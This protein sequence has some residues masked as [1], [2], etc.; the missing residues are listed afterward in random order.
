LA[1]PSLDLIGGKKG[2]RVWKMKRHLIVSFVLVLLFLVLAFPISPVPRGNAYA[3]RP[4]QLLLDVTVNAYLLPQC[5]DLSVRIAMDG[6]F[7]DYTTPH[8]FFLLNGTH[9]FTVPN[10]D[11]G[12]HPFMAWSTGEKTP[13]IIASFGGTYTAYYGVSPPSTYNVTVDTSFNGAGN[14]NVAITEDGVPT[15]F[16]TPYTFS[17]LV[18][19][20]NFTV[21]STD[22][23]GHPFANWV[24][25]SGSLKR[26]TTITVS[27]GGTYTACYDIGLCRFVTPSDQAVVAVASNKSW[28]EMLDYVSSHITYGNGTIWQLPNETLALGSG[29]CRDYATLCVSMLRACGYTAYVIIGTAN[30]SGVPEGHVWVG[31]D[32]NGTVVHVEPQWSWYNQRFVNFT[33]YHAEQYVNENGVYPPGASEDPRPLVTF[34]ES[35]L[36]SRVE[37]WVD[38][39][40]DNQS[41]TSNVISF[42]GPNGTYTYSV[43][44]SGYIVSPSAGSV[45]VNG[46]NINEEV[47]FAMPQIQILRQIIVLCVFIIIIAI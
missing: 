19:T 35:G 21:P 45:T 36:P 26:F 13:T 23:S 18:G 37:W 1:R 5:A 15:G 9:A 7:T 3:F 34:T 44:S 31:I 17:G 46:A 43:G 29:Q 16:N 8:T 39:N 33:V 11:S 2:G 6:S 4:P 42:Y 47:T 24:D 28:V 40:G 41:S 32:L 12:G 10:T 30:F 20:H 27:S 38:L 25:P 14:V 22:S